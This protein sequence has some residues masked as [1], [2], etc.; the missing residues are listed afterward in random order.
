[1][2]AKMTI[3]L[4]VLQLSK[5]QFDTTKDTK[6]QKCKNTKFKVCFFKCV[7]YYGVL[8]G[9]LHTKYFSNAVTVIEP[10]ETIIMECMDLIS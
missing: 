2:S 4:G 7:S 10:K 9:T 6:K 5:V 8:I 3:S 1:M